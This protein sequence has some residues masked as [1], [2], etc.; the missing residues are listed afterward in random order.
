MRHGCG[1]QRLAHLCRRVGPRLW[2]V[3]DVGLDEMGEQCEG[4][5]P[6]EV[7]ELDRDRR[8]YPSWTISTSVHMDGAGAAVA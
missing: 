3:R 4:L 6:P 1:G 2:S 7:A 5:L 8:R